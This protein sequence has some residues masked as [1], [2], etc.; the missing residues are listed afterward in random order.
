MSSTTVIV[1]CMDLN[2]Q[3]LG[4]LMMSISSESVG[5]LLGKILSVRSC[6]SCGQAVVRH[7]NE[8]TAAI[9]LPEHPVAKM[10][11]EITPQLQREWGSYAKEV[12]PCQVV[13]AIFVDSDHV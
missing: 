9:L 10:L 2:H 13:G 4:M 5:D 6:T 1:N 7:S 8:S 11:K 3:R 12:T